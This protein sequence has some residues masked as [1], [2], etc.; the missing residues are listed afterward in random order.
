MICAWRGRD[1]PDETHPTHSW[2]VTR[3]PELAHELLELGVRHRP[4][5]AAEECALCGQ[6][7]L[8]MLIAAFEARYD[9]N[10]VRPGVLRGSP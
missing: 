9:V 4:S 8:V 3:Q 1:D 5:G 7:L 2:V 10:H 6:G